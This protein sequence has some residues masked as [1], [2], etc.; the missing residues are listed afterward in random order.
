MALRTPTSLLGPPTTRIDGRDKV[1]GAA[2]YGSDF[3]PGS[4]AWAFL[5]TSP[6]ARGRILDFEERAARAVPGVLDIFTYHDIGER[7][8]PGKMML[9]DGYMGSTIAPLQSEHVH[10]AGQIVAIVVAESFEAAREAAHVLEVRYQADT[11]AATFDDPGTS[12]APA[13][14]TDPKVGDFDS[15]FAAA[16]V[17]VDAQYETA[18]QHHNPIELFTTVAAWDGDKLTVWE[19]SQNVWGFKNGLAAQLK[20]SPDDVRVV[21]P[22]VGGAFGSRGSLTQRTALIAFA[23]RK[24]GR[25]VK[26]VAT[27]DQGFSIATFRAETRH[28]VQLGAARD[29]KLTALRHEGWEVTSRPDP[30]SVAGTDA[31]TRLF[32][33]QRGFQSQHCTCGSQYSRLH[34]QSSRDAV[35]VRT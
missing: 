17:Q 30:Y 4:L 3:A 19:S 14:K 20:M 34:A 8:S 6:I 27:R 29:G 1:T 12:I 32:M 7:V 15:A 10:H 5:K 11:P 31:S 35:S 24:V 22:F 18:T 21:S 28:H 2:R 9:P 13:G 25:P 26:L 33:R 16:A 23:A